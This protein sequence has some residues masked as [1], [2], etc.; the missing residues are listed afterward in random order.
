MSGSSNNAWLGH[1]GLN[2]AVRSFITTDLPVWPPNLCHR[3]YVSRQDDTL[4]DP[5]SLPFSIIYLPPSSPSAQR[6]QMMNPELFTFWIAG[7]IKGDFTVCLFFFTTRDTVHTQ[8]IYSVGRDVQRIINDS[9]LHTVSSLPMTSI[10][11][12]DSSFELIWMN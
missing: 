12:F 3:Q 11:I 1:R 8:K 10:G 2:N 4:S 5:P 6:C 9:T 7:M